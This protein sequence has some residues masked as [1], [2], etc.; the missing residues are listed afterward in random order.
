MSVNL[1]AVSSGANAPE[2]H[3]LVISLI[4]EA[5]AQRLEAGEQLD[6][7][8]LTQQGE[9]LVAFRQIVIGD[10]RIEMM[11]MVISDIAGEPS[12]NCGQLVER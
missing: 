2:S 1:A 7:L 8:G 9:S 12:K 6:R 5:V 3:Q 4:P 11:N 10:T